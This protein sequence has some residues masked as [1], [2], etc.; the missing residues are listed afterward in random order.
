M[1]SVLSMQRNMHSGK[2]AETKISVSDSDEDSENEDTTKTNQILTKIFG[3]YNITA[4][5]GLNIKCYEIIL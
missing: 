1:Q 5:N 3:S 4:G 2:K